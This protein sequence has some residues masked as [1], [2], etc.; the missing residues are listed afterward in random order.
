MRIIV[1]KDVWHSFYIDGD[2]AFKLVEELKFNRLNCE[3]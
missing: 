2:E 3:E 1:K